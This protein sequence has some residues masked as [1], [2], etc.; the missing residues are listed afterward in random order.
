MSFI[1]L[2]SALAL[3]IT[4]LLLDINV[5]YS[6]VFLVVVVLINWLFT[7]FLFH[8]FT[9]RAIIK[10]NDKIERYEELNDIG[11]LFLVSM[12]TLL[13][14]SIDNLPFMAFLSVLCFAFIYSSNIYYQN[15]FFVL[16]GYKIYKVTTKHRV[17]YAITKNKRLIEED[18][19]QFTI[20]DNVIYLI[21][22]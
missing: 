13:T 17:Y 14:L 8:Y 10:E 3:P 6:I 20:D 19:K 1:S 5:I 7:N 2:L 9:D 12:I 15:P 21:N 4:K 18:A 16:L 11:L 22:R